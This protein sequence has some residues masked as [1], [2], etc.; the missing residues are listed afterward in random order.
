MVAAAI[1][2]F[3]LEQKPVNKADIKTLFDAYMSKIVT[4]SRPFYFHTDDARLRRM[5]VR[6]AADGITP[7]PSKLPDVG[8]SDPA[9]A[10]KWLAQLVNFESQGC[11][12]IRLQ[13]NPEFTK[14]YSV[15]LS[16]PNVTNCDGVAAAD[17]I[18]AGEVAAEVISLF[19]NYYWFTKLGSVERQKT[20]LVVDVGPLVGKAVTIVTLTETTGSCQFR[21]P[22][23]YP[24]QGGSTLFVYHANAV[25]ELREFAVRR[26]ELTTVGKRARL[27]KLWNE[28]A[29]MQL[30]STLTYLNPANA[31]G[32]FTVTVNTTAAVAGRK[33]A[34]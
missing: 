9:I 12:H 6:L 22:L 5:F 31:I 15:K 26:G 18:S 23:V 28:V 3:K 7:T 34:M 17:C 29:G 21:H 30:G 14:F 13:L 24:N 4:P 2:W 10:G 1:A 11:G 19:Y 8:P 32:I 33:M 27:I 20:R 25:A 16:G